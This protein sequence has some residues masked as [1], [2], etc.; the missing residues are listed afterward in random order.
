MKIGKP[1]FV[2][3]LAVLCCLPVT[4]IQASEPDGLADRMLIHE[5]QSRYALAHD[6]TDPQMYASVFTEDAELIGGGRVVAKGRQAL[7]DAASND[8]KRFNPGA[9]EGKR[10]FMTMR[11][12]ITNSVV[13]LTG[14]T[15]AKGI[16]YVLT[17]VNQKNHGPEIMSV[18]RYEDQYVK[19][20]GEWLIARRE[21]F[22]DM[23]NTELGKEIGV[24]P[25]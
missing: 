19:T 11:H 24:I 9:A 14:P 17:I 22:M 2:Y 12:V 4:I 20:K 10:S 13:D 7:M 16:C 15:S 18:G 3:L 1:D 8:R 5:L 25:Q 23:G 21:I 6:L